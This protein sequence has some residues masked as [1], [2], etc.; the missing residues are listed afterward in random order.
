M[1]RVSGFRG[2]KLITYVFIHRLAVVGRLDDA[3]LYYCV[4]VGHRKRFDRIEYTFYK[5]QREQ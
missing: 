3:P 5:V 4:I 1:F 2:I